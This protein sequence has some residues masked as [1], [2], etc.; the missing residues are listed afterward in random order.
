MSAK[1]IIFDAQAKNKILSSLS[2]PGPIKK[3]LIEVM[4]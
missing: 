3:R 1:E 4:K 2:L